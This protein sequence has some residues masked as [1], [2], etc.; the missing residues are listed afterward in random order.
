MA[1]SSTSDPLLRRKCSL[2]LGRVCGSRGILP[3]RYPGVS[4]LIVLGD[5]PS[6]QGGSAEVWRGEAKGRP[7]AVKA[8]RRYSTVP[9]V[10]DQEVSPYWG[11][12]FL[13]AR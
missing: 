3:T 6:G 11:I 10:H 1:S 9:M 8:V 7:V 13:F 5:C 2:A 12:S 4:D